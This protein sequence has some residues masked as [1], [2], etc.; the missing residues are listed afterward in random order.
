MCST[1]LVVIAKTALGPLI[2]GACHLQSP[3][4]LSVRATEAT[5]TDCRLRSATGHA[6]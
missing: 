5:I 6:H 1:E 2:M 4:G 3:A